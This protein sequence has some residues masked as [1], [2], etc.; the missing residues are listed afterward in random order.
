MKKLYLN[1]GFKIVKENVPC[2]FTKF[3][4]RENEILMIRDKHVD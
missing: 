3:G 1:N 4:K 2:K